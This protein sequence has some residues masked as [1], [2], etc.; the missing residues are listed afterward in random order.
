[1]R[2]VTGPLQD[3]GGAASSSPK[4]HSSQVNDCRRRLCQ[5]CDEMTTSL[6]PTSRLHMLRSF[7]DERLST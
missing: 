1:M 6:T 7:N 4:S 5:A 2:W 3:G